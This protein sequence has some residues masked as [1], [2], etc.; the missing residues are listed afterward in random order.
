MNLLIVL[1]ILVLIFVLASGDSQ[2]KY[3]ER[4]GVPAR[5]IVSVGLSR[6]DHL[7]D[8]QK[9]YSPSQSRS[10][11]KIPQNFQNYILFDASYPLR[12]YVTIQELS[13]VTNALLNFVREHPS[14][15]LMIKPH[16]A[17]RPGWLEDL[18]DYFS[19]KNIYLLDK[20]WSPIMP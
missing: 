19:L 1:T 10:H 4:L 7:A 17:H 2:I 5:R 20:I 12:G 6:Y 9:D 13:L 16:P 18:V 3:L 15:A 11:L 8:F 14:V